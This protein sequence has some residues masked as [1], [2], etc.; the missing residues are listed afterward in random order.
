[1]LDMCP[2]ER[3]EL[4]ENTQTKMAVEP[5]HEYI[6]PPGKRGSAESLVAHDDLS[7]GLSNLTAE[8]HQPR[9]RF[10]EVPTL[11]SGD[12][13]Q[14]LFATSCNGVSKA[15]SKQQATKASGKSQQPLGLRVHQCHAVR[16]CSLVLLYLRAVGGRLWR[17]TSYPGVHFTHAGHAAHTNHAAYSPC[18]PSTRVLRPRDPRALEAT[19][20]PTCILSA[21][22]SAFIALWALAQLQL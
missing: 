18:G 9:Q 17:K 6:A 21:L 8:S 11:D 3:E 10:G 12:C 2:V 16:R 14:Q 20:D 7:E 22:H 4:Q 5:F 13:K 1:M 19:D 15:V